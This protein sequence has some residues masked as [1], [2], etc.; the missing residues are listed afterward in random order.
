MRF[1][2]G[3]FR[4]FKWLIN[5]VTERQLIAS[6][7]GRNIYN[8]E[9]ITVPADGLAPL[10]ARPSAGTVMTKFGSCIHGTDSP[11]MNMEEIIWSHSIKI[12]CHIMTYFIMH[13]CILS[14][15][16]H[17]E[18]Q[19]N[20]L[21]YIITMIMQLKLILNTFMTSLLCCQHELG[22]FIFMSTQASHYTQCFCDFLSNGICL[23]MHMGESFALSKSNIKTFFCFYEIFD[24]NNCKSLKMRFKFSSVTLPLFW[25]TH[26]WSQA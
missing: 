2:Q 17:R 26:G 15:L 10:G 1:F 25:P 3:F 4:C 8:F 24:T 20:K 5:M 14:E 18:V 13:T 22:V 21:I 23:I 6:K 12:F 7:P 11:R 19:M 16:K 9:V